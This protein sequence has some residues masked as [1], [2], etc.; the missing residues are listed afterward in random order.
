VSVAQ[1]RDPR[2]E[3]TEPDKLELLAR[4]KSYEGR[5]VGPAQ[6]APDAVNLPMVRHW[7]EAIGDTLPVYLDAEAAASSVHGGLVAPPTMLQAWTMR[8]FAR[9]S[10]EPTLQDELLRLLDSAG[11][12]SVVATNSEQHYDRY[13]RPGDQ[14][15][16]STTISE[17][18]DEKE[19]GLGVGHFITSRIEFHDQQGER[20]AWMN[21][22]LLKFRPR[23][24]VVE[25]PARTREE[26]GS[27]PLRPRPAVTQDTAFWF[28]GAREGRLLIQRCASCGELRH[29]PMPA[30]PHCRSFDWDTL[31]ATGRGTLYS[32]V[33]IHHPEV[34]AF[35]YPLVVGLVELEEGTRLVADIVGVAPGEMH[36]GMPL[37][38]EMVAVDDDLTLPRFRPVPA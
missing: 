2:E 4:L 15:T 23:P 7:C 16:Q 35:D 31:E 26:G 24:K 17:V 22:R 11:F 18:S 20:V 28:E 3:A 19:T 27:R 33:T 32:V 36:I 25:P 37:Q 34:P 14:I 13:L 9:R 38:A 12:T 10:T 8:G 1:Q 6:V 30:C 5:L 21:W 29:P